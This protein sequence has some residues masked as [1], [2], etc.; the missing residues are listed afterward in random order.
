MKNTLLL[1][2]CL[3]AVANASPTLSLHLPP[4]AFADTEVTTNC[5]FDCGQRGVH[6][7]IVDMTFAGTTSNS[8]QLAFGRDADM[9]GALAAAE[10]DVTFA[11]E[12]GEW[13]LCGLSSNETFRSEAVTTNAIKELRW[14]LRL[15]RRRPK[16]LV[17]SENGASIFP[18]LSDCPP[19]WLYST[20]WDLLRLTVR[21]VDAPN[22]DVGVKL[23]VTGYV[24]NV[25]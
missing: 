15:Q 20:D 17:A 18:D 16:R 25:R 21:G 2:F 6:D 13:R 24:I 14:D 8:V 22:E 19:P 11:W 10:T 23:N 3:P 4:S 7:L 1:L 12:C 9:D 5:P